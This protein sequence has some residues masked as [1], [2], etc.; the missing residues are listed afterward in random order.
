MKKLGS[1][2]VLGILITVLSIMTAAANYSAYQI[3]GVGGGHT[4]NAR[5]LL[6]DANT[7]SIAALQLVIYDYQLYDGWYVTYDTNPDASD[8]YWNN[9]SYALVDSYNRDTGPFDEAYYDELYAVA[10]DLYAQAEEEFAA[11]DAAY[12]REAV[13]Q[14]TMLMAAVGLA[15][16]AY[17]SMLKEEQRLRPFFAF[18]SL[19]MLAINIFQFGTALLLTF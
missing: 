6:A 15:F 5:Q 18:L 16:A 8:Y 17:A 13:L 10:D 3:G 1:D 4:A 7:E 12:A 14:L 11:A 9:F 19:V 2:I